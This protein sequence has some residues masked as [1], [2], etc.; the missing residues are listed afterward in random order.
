MHDVLDPHDGDAGFLD[1]LDQLNEFGALGLGQAAGDLIEKKKPRRA[2]QRPRQFE[3]LSPQQIEC[4][5]AAIG[6]ADEARPLE[7]VAARVDDLRLALLAAVDRGDQKV[8]EYGE[9]LERLR[10][11][12]RAADAGDAAGA[13]RRVRD[14]LTV[15]WTLPVSGFCSPVMRLNSVDLPA[16]FGPMMPSASPGA[17]SSSTPSTA[18]SEPNDFVRLFN[19]RITRWPPGRTPALIGPAF[20]IVSPG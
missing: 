16:P 18:L 10:N 14:I 20:E 2:R 5:G 1:V 8:F 19:F 15:K 13:R 4:A 12:E 17:T 6:G 7:N 3:A 11:L 9:A